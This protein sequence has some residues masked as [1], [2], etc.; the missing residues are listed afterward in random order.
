MNNYE[1]IKAM[2]INDMAEFLKINC[3]KLVIKKVASDYIEDNLIKQW[4]EQESEEHNDQPITAA[5]RD[6]RD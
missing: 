4:L 5:M 3:A 2:T 1:R 6:L